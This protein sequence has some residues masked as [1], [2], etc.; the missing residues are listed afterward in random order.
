MPVTRIAIREGRNPAYTKALLDEIYEAMR[1]TVAIKDGD[2]FMAITEHGE[3]EFAYGP[4]PGRDRSDDLVQIQVSGPPARPSRPSSRCTKRLTSASEST[5]VSG[6][7]TCS[8]R[9]SRRRGELVIRQR[10]DAV[11]QAGDGG[12]DSVTTDFER[13]PLA[14]RRVS[15]SVSSRRAGRS[16]RIEQH[17]P[18]RPLT[19]RPN[20]D[21]WG[22]RDSDPPPGSA[23]PLASRRPSQARRT[24]PWGALVTARRPWRTSALRWRA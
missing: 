24:R 14:P 8:S 13:R 10:R 11:L 5:R 2:R 15:A 3:H 20:A 9:W 4:F 22:A 18:D 17:T 21:A 1:E 12:R 7:R 6:P 19:C 16:S 23:L